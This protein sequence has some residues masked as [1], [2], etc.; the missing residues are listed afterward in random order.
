M[1]SSPLNPNADVIC[2]GEALIDRLGPLGG[3]PAV[4]KPV[5]DQFGGAPANVACG[6]ARLGTNV[7]FIGR[8]G[9]DEFGK[10]FFKL[11]SQRGINLNCL[12]F[13]SR[14]PTRLV[15]V[16]RALN[17]E[18]EFFGFLGD[19]GDGF[20][21]EYIELNE[22]KAKWAS[23][24]KTAKWLLLGTIPLAKVISS[25]TLF[26][27]VSESLKA[28]IKI[29]LDINWRPTFWNQSA[30][31]SSSP[32]DKVKAKIFQLIKYTSLLKL[33]KEEAIY[34]FNTDN[35]LD[36]SNSLPQKPD[37][38]ITNG[39]EAVKWNIN[40][41]SGITNVFNSPTI[42]DTTG[43]GDAFMSGLMHK[44]INTSNSIMN[45]E[46]I[47][48]II[49]FSIACGAIVCG[50]PGAIMPQPMRKDVNQLLAS[51]GSIT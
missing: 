27:I 38:V 39:G 51:L 12:Q 48:E 5:E 1:L 46:T 31:P 40:T 29:A 3:D 33:S 44:I 18:R 8:L 9:S 50:S 26:W 25:E 13:D 2:F 16:R 20:A 41:I 32:S 10:G 30:S 42:I 22:V 35:P 43:A 11:M 23:I 4:D 36:I 19:M 28:N 37:I 49:L 34:F 17:G 6:L 47:Q 14:K 24:S 15:L 45:K 7:A 21:D